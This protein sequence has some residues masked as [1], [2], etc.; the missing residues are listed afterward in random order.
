MKLLPLTRKSRL[1][2]GSKG[3]K[4]HAVQVIRVRRGYRIGACTHKIAIV[5]RSLVGVRFT[6]ESRQSADMLACPLGA[7]SVLTRRST[8]P[9]SITSS[10]MAKR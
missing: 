5:R 7:N 1:F 3:G 2:W 10:A 8:A 6:P 4:S 9:H